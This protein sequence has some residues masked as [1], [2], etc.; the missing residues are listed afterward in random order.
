M[1]TF[2]RTIYE[3]APALVEV[4]LEL[5]QRRVEV[6]ILALDEQS[7]NGNGGATDALGWP[8]GFFEETFGS[9]PDFPEREPQ[10]EYE[11]RD[12]LVI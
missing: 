7:P 8:V 4:P 3:V 12:E 2:Q 10:G 9:I 5:R 11:I 1:L 6:I